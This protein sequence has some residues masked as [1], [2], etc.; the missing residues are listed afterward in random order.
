MSLTAQLPTG[1]I[2]DLWSYGTPNDASA[3]I[4]EV[5]FEKAQQDLRH[6]MHAAHAMIY[7]RDDTVLWDKYNVTANILM[8]MRFDG[9]LGFAGG[10]L[11]HGSESAVEGLNRELEEEINLDLKKYPLSQEDHICTHVN[12]KKKLVMHFYAKEMK[13]TEFLEI[14]RNALGAKEWGV[15]S[16]GIIRV[17]L[18]MVEDKTRGFPLF[19]ANQFAGSAREQLLIAI[20][21]RKILTKEQLNYFIDC[22]RKHVGLNST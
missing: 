19:L 7:A 14:E 16:L 10:L 5:T 20:C 21:K 6:Y 9:N 17:P 22:Y 1:E 12:D 2:V 3:D 18:Y 4:R 8:Q 11:D 15:E 13:K